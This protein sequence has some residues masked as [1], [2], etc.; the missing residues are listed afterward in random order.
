MQAF[1]TRD[2]PWIIP[3][4]ASEKKMIEWRQYE[5]QM[6]ILERF[7]VLVK[8]AVLIIIPFSAKIIVGRL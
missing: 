6:I 7:L 3:A 1:M 5:F 2:I 8:K 4:C